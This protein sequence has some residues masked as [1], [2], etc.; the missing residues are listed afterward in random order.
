MSIFMI[1]LIG[2]NSQ[3]LFYFNIILFSYLGKVFKKYFLVMPINQH[4]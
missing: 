1:L 2:I 4:F 3:I